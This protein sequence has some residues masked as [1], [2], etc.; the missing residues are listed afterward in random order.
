MTL[1][2]GVRTSRFKIS[3]AKPSLKYSSSGSRLMLANGRTAM[4][5]FRSS[6]LTAYCSSA[7]RNSAALENRCEGCLARQRFMIVSRV[8]GACSGWG[9]SRRT[10]LST[11]DIVSPA[12]ARSP[13]SSSYNTAPKLKN[14]RTLV[15]RPA[16]RLL[17]RHVGRRAH[18]HAGH[19]VGYIRAPVRH[20][21]G[22]AE[23]EQL[24][25]SLRGNQNIAELEIAMQDAMGVRLFQG[26]GDLD[27]EVHRLVRGHGAGGPLAFDKLHHQVVR[28]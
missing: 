1:S 14:V 7:A 4:E 8:A 22:Q 2:P 21:L 10:A 16:F 17:G 24:G 20:R 23:I 3:S 18:D 25:N 13:E 5:G 9:S 12:K 19:R 27:S 28:P 6:G 26:R 11:C 15:E